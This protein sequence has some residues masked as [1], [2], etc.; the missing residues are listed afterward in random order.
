MLTVDNWSAKVGSKNDKEIA[1]ITTAKTISQI[2]GIFNIDN[3]PIAS[4]EGSSK[5]I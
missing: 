1:H 2:T 5:Q 4:S 3:M